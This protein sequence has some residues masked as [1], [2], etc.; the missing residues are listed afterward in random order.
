LKLNGTKMKQKIDQMTSSELRAL[1]AELRPLDAR[2]LMER[3]HEVL[4]ARQALDSL[5]E[6]LREARREV[7][8]A[9]RQLY[10][11]RLAHPFQA[12]LHGM[13]LM[14][15][16]F[17]VE[18]E[19]IKSAAETEAL[20]LAERVHHA[21]EYVRNMENEVEARIQLKQAPVR[22][23]MAE[24]EYLRRKKAAQ[25]LVEQRQTQELGNNLAAFTIHKLKREMK[26]HSHG[27]DRAEQRALPEALRKTGQ[28][29]EM[30]EF[31]K[32]A[33]RKSK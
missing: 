15:S 19:E 28:V 30:S 33:S 8:A 25:E 21:E 9:D 24:L 17:L 5:S 2:D 31:W 13:G 14:P 6:Q 27:D 23:R 20:K 16:R 18:R 12:R 22:E 10:N 4:A 7:M 32:V 26:A 1:I 3:E 11:W 29:S